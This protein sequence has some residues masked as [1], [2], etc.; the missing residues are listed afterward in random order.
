MIELRDGTAI[1][2][3]RLKFQPSADLL[4]LE[5][6]PSFKTIRQQLGWAGNCGRLW[7]REDRSKRIAHAPF[8]RRFL[9]HCGL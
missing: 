3:D 9:V 4:L 2:R 1:D 5:V 8:P 7:H 6:G